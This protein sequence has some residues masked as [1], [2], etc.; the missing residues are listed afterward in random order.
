M[1]QAWKESGL[2]NKEFFTLTTE[3]G[4]VL[5]AWQIKPVNFDATKKYPVVMLQYSGP[6]SQRV[7]DTWCKRFG[8]YL[9]AQG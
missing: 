9:A 6:A 8:H 3:R 1:L 4:D 2:P 5:N 7:T